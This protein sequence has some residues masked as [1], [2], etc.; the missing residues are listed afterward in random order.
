LSRREFTGKVKGEI[1]LR[2]TNAAGVV[3][4]EGCGLPLGKKPY[5]IDHTIA[6]ALVL[7]KRRPLTVDDGKLLGKACCHDPKTHG[8]DIPAIAQAKRREAKDKGYARKPTRQITSAPF[9]PGANKRT[10]KPKMQPKQLFWSPGH[11]D[12]SGT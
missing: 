3:C 7:D 10:P 12:G 4:C 1:V 9:A 11:S 2:A 6:D 5:N 8:E